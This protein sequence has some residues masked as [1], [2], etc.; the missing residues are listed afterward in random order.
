MKIATVLLLFLFIQSI[1]AQEKR[2][3]KA[4][5][6]ENLSININGVFEET[7]W[8]NANWEND[9]IQHEP[10]E[11][12]APTRQTE[13]AILYDANNLYVAIRSLDDPDSISMRMSRR[14]ETDGDLV[15]VYIDSYFDKRTSFA[16][17]VSAAGVR[18]DMVSTNDGDNEDNTWDPIWYAKTSVTK[19]G[20]N[21]EM[22]IPLTQLRFEES[23][24]Q[25]WG[26]NVFRYIFR[27]R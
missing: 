6:A 19:N 24:E 20:W 15:G 16:F 8:Q 12:K 18:S 7:E 17:V 9:F 25:I 27:E 10:E 3:Y 26:L 21:A 5:T 23:E 13:Y 11:G 22:R 1:S 14:D 4:S 2:T